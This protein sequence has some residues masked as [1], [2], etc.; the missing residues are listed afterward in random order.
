[1]GNL[2][3][4][5]DLFFA[6]WAAAFFNP[7]KRIFWGYLLSALL[8][9]L[10]W[11]LFRHR[12]SLAAALKSIF[13][14]QS[15]CSKSARADYL[16]MI[17]NG[18]IMNLLAPKL[19]AKTAVAALLFGLLHDVFD[20][21][22]IIT[23]MPGWAVALSFTAF[24]FILDDFARYWLHRWLHTVPMLWQFHKVHH[25]ATALNPLTVFRTHPVEGILFSLRGAL[26]QGISIA[27]FVFFF[28][29][30]VSLIT[31]LGAT[32]F[33]F[34]FNILG[35]NLRH[36][37]VAI[38]YPRL[39]EKIFISPAQHHL[40]HSS[41]E[42]HHDKNYGVILAVWDWWFGSHH[43]SEKDEELVFGVHDMHDEEHTL[44]SLY[45][46]PLRDCYQISKYFVATYASVISQKFKQN[47][48]IKALK[49]L[50]S[51]I[52]H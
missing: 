39:I 21:R 37:P 5:A 52:A 22:P 48:S 38:H 16:L 43:F 35:A 3:W 51:S 17:I 20:G 23:A 10:A 14:Y 29:S 28:G 27:L 26:V 47:N 50:T 18:A 6:E 33:S 13:N 31:V 25:S 2:D 36:S 15:W 19:L 8:L 34:T 30:Q 42:R 1:M 11:Q 4:A 7:Q 12:Q 46:T 9:G 32:L 49:K 40:H 24:L 45:V 44:Y 41:A